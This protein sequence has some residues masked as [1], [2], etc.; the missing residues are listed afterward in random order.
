MQQNS[1]YITKKK[2]KI[3]NIITNIIYKICKFLQKIWYFLC[4]NI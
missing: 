2:A 1:Q 4:K 3:N